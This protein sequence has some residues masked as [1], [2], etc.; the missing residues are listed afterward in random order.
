MSNSEPLFP[1]GKQHVSFSEIKDWKE[2]P[3][4]HKLKY[5]DKVDMFEPSPYLDFGTAVHEGCETLLENKKVDRE[6]L[7]KD[8]KDAWEEHGFDNPEWYQ[9]Q[10]G[11]YKHVPVEKWCEWAE[12]MWDEVVPFLDENFPGWEL[13]EVEENL[14]E[15]IPS[16]DLYFKGFIDAIIKAP[17]KRGKGYEYWII[18]WKTAGPGGWRSDKKRDFKM[19]LQLILYKKYWSVKHNIDQGDIRCAFVTL[20][21][22]AK[23]GKVCNLVTVS[24]GPKTIQKGE[25]VLSN[26]ISSVKRKMNLKNRNSCSFCVYR[27]TVHCT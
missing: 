20:G 11:W 23:K 9:A 22:G 1:T 21:R 14:Y 19:Q 13:H 24:A 5:V 25:K 8:I 3:Y 4:R 10:P 7:I 27:N 26:M 18:D 12:N 15:E 16:A 17:K 2:C 6:K